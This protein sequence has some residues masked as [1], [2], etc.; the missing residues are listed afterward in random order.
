MTESEPTDVDLLAAVARGVVELAATAQSSAF[1]LPYPPGVQLAL[2]RWVL[3]ALTRGK[4]PPAGVPELMAWCR[5]PRVGGWPLALPD[6]FLFGDACLIHPVADEPTQTCAELGSF[7]RHGV[8]EQ[9]AETLLARL[10]ETCG[11]GERFAKCRDFLIRRP[12]LLK[13]DPMEL[14]QP[15][16]AQVWNLVKGLYGPVPARFSAGK[17]V[18]LCTGC[19]LLAK[20]FIK[21]TAWCE[22]NCPPDR[23]EFVTTH[24]PRHARVLPFALRLFLALPGRIEQVVHG[25]LT[26]R[27]PLLPL[28]LGVHRAVGP[29][30]VSRLFQC[31]DREQPGPAALR[32]AKTAALLGAPLDIVVPD[33]TVER[34]EYRKRF[35]L[36]L[37]VGAP[38]R[39]VSTTEFTT[40]GPTGRERTSYA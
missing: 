10:Y 6:D 40:S 32:A 30:G 15:A 19:G 9:E 12:V 28:G 22:G 13:L 31:H 38:V 7:G 20:P 4:P 36:A 24:E 37:P 5:K 33:R 1:G 11:S 14:M 17:A 18:H 3:A 8:V 21:E 29:D 26:E 16:L 34:P 23:R 2:D 27:A 35:E 25:L 39:M